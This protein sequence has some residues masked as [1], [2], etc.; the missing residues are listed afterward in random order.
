MTRKVDPARYSV[1]A[2]D[3]SFQLK[4]LGLARR[5]MKLQT[6]GVNWLMDFAAASADKSL[7]NSCVLACTA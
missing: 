5:L 3:L 7:L 6:T 2:G 4:A 1:K